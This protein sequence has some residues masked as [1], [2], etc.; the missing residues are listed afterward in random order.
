[1]FRFYDVNGDG[2]L[3]IDELRIVLKSI[4]DIAFKV[5]IYTYSYLSNLD[6]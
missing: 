1:M 2:I 6:D 4:S 3:T 5:F